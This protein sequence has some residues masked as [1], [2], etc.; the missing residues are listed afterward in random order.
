MLS[1]NLF[2]K[3]CVKITV[4]RSI[5]KKIVTACNAVYF[6]L[7]IDLMHITPP[8]TAKGYDGSHHL[9]YAECHDYLTEDVASK[10]YTRYFFKI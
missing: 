10:A 8:V 7:C 4:L 5:L 3:L 6:R 2:N 9:R 1:T